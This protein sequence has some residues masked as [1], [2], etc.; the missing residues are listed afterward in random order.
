MQN[1]QTFTFVNCKDQFNL[2]TSKAKA[3]NLN[4]LLDS[5]AMLQVSYTN[6]LGKDVDKVH[7]HALYTQLEYTCCLVSEFT[8]VMQVGLHHTPSHT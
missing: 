5:K 1:K 2:L 4:L 6:L 3:T 7:P 8:Q